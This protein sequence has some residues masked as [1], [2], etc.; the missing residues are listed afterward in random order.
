MLSLKVKDLRNRKAFHLL[1]KSRIVN[2]FLFIN[3]LSKN[4]IIPLDAITFFSTRN[5]RV[6]NYSKTKITRRCV[7]NNR[8]RGS[9]RHFGISRIYLRELMQFG[10]V[11]G[12][13]KAVW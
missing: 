6:Q 12:Y 1:E 13:S 8:N 2:K 5:L 10:L 3:V 9:I 7:F 11:P 4:G